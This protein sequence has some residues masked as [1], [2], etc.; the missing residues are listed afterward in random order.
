MLQIVLRAAAIAMLTAALM[1]LQ[2]IAVALGLPARRR[3]PWVYHR[4]ICKIFGVRLTVHGA[5]IADQPLLI[6]S[7][8]I[9]WLDISVISALSP[10]VFIA[11][12]EVAN[13]PF[14]GLL[15]KLQRSIFVNRTRRRKTAEVNAEIGRRL[16]Q[17]D[18][19]LLF[20]EGT[21]SDG[22][23]VLPFR[24]A[25]VGA[26]RDALTAADHVR[27]IWIQPLS[28][29]YTGQL[30]LPLGRQ[31]RPLIAWYGDAS[32]LPHLV[33]VARRGAVDVTVT[34]GAPLAFDENSDRKTVTRGLE[35]TVR[36]LTASALRARPDV[37]ATPASSS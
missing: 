13:W 14:F 6:V 34:W 12:H 7:N 32:L 11:K 27:R 17:G 28:L 31:H 22:N 8:H 18:P 24:S 33:E 5:P 3:I 23:R 29:A 25:L 10:V 19:V 9:S 2:G 1:P 26:A 35:A 20:A 36:R 30:G 21:S 15:A 4:A 37:H 16:A